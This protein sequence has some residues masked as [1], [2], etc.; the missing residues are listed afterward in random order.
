MNASG[1]NGYTALLV[2]ALEGHPEVV[3]ALLA[4][5]ADVNAK[6]GD[7]ATALMFASAGKRFGHVE[8]GTMLPSGQV[9]ERF[10]LPELPQPQEIVQ[11]LLAAKADVNAKTTTHDS[12][13]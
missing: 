1:T 13:H 4:A 10:I 12:P 3:R 9:V 11:A 7:G 6:R 5:K 2:A 8:S